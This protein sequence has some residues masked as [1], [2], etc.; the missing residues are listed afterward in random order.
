MCSRR[1]GKVKLHNFPPL[2]SKRYVI[3]LQTVVKYI[4]ENTTF[5]VSSRRLT[6]ESLF[7]QMSFS[8]DAL[9]LLII[10]EMLKLESSPHHTEPA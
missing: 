9:S 7:K 2:K 4:K 5:C 1:Q 10:V 8:D 3:R 6:I